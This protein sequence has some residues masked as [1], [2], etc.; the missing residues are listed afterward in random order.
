MAALG[1]FERTGTAEL[2]FDKIFWRPGS[3]S[4]AAFHFVYYDGSEK[5]K[6]WATAKSRN[7]QKAARLQR[8]FHPAARS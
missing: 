2:D 1:D 8:G 7:E 4:R 5:Q 6:L 3:L